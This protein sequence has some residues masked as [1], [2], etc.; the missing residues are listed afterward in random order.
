LGKDKAKD[1]EYFMRREN[2]MDMVRKALGNSTTARQFAEMSLAGGLSGA[3]GGA[4]EAMMTGNMDAKTVLSAALVGGAVA[5]HRAINFKVAQRVGEM[6]ASND[7]K[8]L[9]TAIKML[10]TNPDAGR[11][12]L[13]AEKLIE[14]LSG[15]GAGSAPPM[16]PAI[17]TGRA[18]QQ[19]QQ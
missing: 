6:L 1:L 2:M 8:V 4:G 11:A 7:P 17:A 10:K 9:S 3:A 5:G 15:Q 19:Q 16:L 13:K 12:M 18:D 14:K